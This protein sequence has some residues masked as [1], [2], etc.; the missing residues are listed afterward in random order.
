[1]SIAVCF[2]TARSVAADW[3]VR[4]RTR[5]LSAHMNPPK[6]EL[7]ATGSRGHCDCINDL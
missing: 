2:E 6:I 1:M 3:C 4:E 5:D 7:V